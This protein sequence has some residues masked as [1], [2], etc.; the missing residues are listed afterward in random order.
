MEREYRIF[1]VCLLE[2][3]DLY[4]VGVHGSPP[5]PLFLSNFWSVVILLFPCFHSQIRWHLFPNLLA[6]TLC[7][8]CLQYVLPVLNCIRPLSSLCVAENLK[9]VFLIISVSS[10]VMPVLFK[11]FLSLTYSVYDI[12]NSRRQNH[13]FVCSSLF[14]ICEEIFTHSLAY[15]RLD[16]A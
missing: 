1:L 15:R 8:S 4:D 9:C 13:I 16:V 10:F 3:I 6:V 11:T 5:L 12:L 7:F 14:L 2:T